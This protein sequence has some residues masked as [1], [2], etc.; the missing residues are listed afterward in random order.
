MISPR[1][2]A[3]DM[4]VSEIPNLAHSLRST[5]CAVVRVRNK[6]EGANQRVMRGESIFARVRFGL[7]QSGVFK[8]DA[9]NTARYMAARK[10]YN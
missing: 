3:A 10:R 9:T 8:Q 5:R 7:P 6:G 2:A 4:R 1:M